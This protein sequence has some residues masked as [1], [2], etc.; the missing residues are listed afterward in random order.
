MLRTI[1]HQPWKRAAV[2][3]S[4]AAL[5]AGAT[6][7]GA[8]PREGPP[9]GGC[10]PAGGWTLR[11]VTEPGAP[12]QID[13]NGDG[14]VCGKDMNVPAFPGVDNYVDNVLKVTG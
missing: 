13:Q 1:W 4:L 12:A 9:V 10:P 8:F 3:L 14:W 5:V 7:A 11:S 6:A 2:T